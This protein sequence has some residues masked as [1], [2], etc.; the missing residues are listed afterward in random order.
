MQTAICRMAPSLQQTFT[1]CRL[2]F[3]QYGGRNSATIR[4]DDSL[5]GQMRHSPQST[6][7]WSLVTGC[8]GHGQRAP[9]QSIIVQTLIMRISSTHRLPCGGPHRSAQARIE[10]S[11]KEKSD[12][13]ASGHP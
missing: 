3:K 6:D 9:D 13:K 4:N 2:E 11:L 5:S 1:R 12:N 8:L 7:N 10:T